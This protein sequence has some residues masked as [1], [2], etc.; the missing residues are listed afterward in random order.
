MT[1]HLFLHSDEYSDKNDSS[2]STG[3]ALLNC[4]LPCNIQVLPSLIRIQ[5]TGPFKPSRLVQDES[6][7]LPFSSQEQQ[8]EKL[9]SIYNP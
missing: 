8:P 5:A 7:M 2:H 3:E 1:T 4:V 9:K 6:I